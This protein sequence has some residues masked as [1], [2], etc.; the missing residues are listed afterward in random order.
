MQQA[1]GV[2]A[3]RSRFF[4]RMAGLSL[5]IALA[6]FLPTYWLPMVQ[7]RSFPPI[8]H[9]HGVIFVGWNLLLFWQA[10]LVANGRTPDH[11]SWGMVGIALATAMVISVPLAVLNSYAAAAR[12]GME[13]QARAFSVVPITGIAAFALLFTLAVRNVHRPDVHRRLMIAATVPLLQAAVARWFQVALTPPGAVGPPP[14][15]VALPPGL[16]VSAVFFGAMAVHD[17]RTSGLLHPTTMASAAFVVAIQVLTIPIGNSAPWM[18]LANGLAAL[19]P[20]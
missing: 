10:S 3:Q 15:M 1:V 6:G 19:V 12:I 13:P 16:L 14:I 11:R 9:I 20:A 18:A 2:R 7:G 4:V 8:L 5:F 17:K